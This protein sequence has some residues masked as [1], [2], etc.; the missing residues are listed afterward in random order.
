VTKRYLRYALAI[1]FFAN[2]LSYLDRQVVATME[3]QLTATKAKGGLGLTA[4][5]FGWVGSAF[6]IGYMVFAP[7]VGYLITRYSR[8]RIFALCVLV[9]SL[10]TVGSGLATG[11]WMLYATRFFIGVGEA[12]CL[13]IGPTLLSDYFSKEVRGRV[14]SAFFL[15]LPLGGATGY[16]AGAKI[17]QWL[18]WHWAFY[19]AG[20]PGFAVAI[21]IWM[22]VDPKPSEE[23][24]D[25]HGQLVAKPTAPDPSHANRSWIANLV[26]G[27]QRYLSLLKNRTLLF[28][29]LAQAFAVM[30]LQPFL[31]YGIGFF[32]TE[33]QM[34]KDDA[35]ILLAGIA[36]LA[37]AL[38][39]ALSGFI[40]DRLA[41]RTAGAYALLAGIAFCLG[42]PF[43]LIGFTS[44]V[45]PIAAASLGVG[46][47]CYFLCM[48]AVNTQIANSISSEK[49]AM[50]FALAVF[51]LHLLGDTAALPAFGKVSTV[52]GAK[53]TAFLI[54]SCALLLAGASC[55]LAARFAARENPKTSN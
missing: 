28:I 8:P 13:V 7:I 40:G 20:A 42:M 9:W 46:A 43:M 36:L 19:I 41:R 6:T 3:T 15:A 52:V 5:E 21:L 37:G 47:F 29:I 54:F 22:L 12:G 30:F 23:T 4:T 38:G 24:V 14:L 53:Q 32:E 25:A 55:L 35:S 44:K 48:P 11:K 51:I 16:I 34:K 50:A 27:L 45:I 10:A 49:R 2:F 31:H 33:R 18:D 17:T 39:N 26:E 1:I